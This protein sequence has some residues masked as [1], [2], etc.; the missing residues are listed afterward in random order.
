M[1]RQE[2]KNHSIYALVKGLSLLMRA[3]PLPWARM[4]GAAL[5]RLF[6]SLVPYERRKALDTFATAFPEKDSAEAGRVC[7]AAFA[8]L[9]RGG[10]EFLR[11]PSIRE[12]ELRSWVESVDGLEHLRAP[13]RAGRGVVAVTAHLGNWEVLAA[14]TA[15]EG[16]VAVVAQRVYDARFDEALNE[17]R[18]GKGITVFKRDTSVKP[19]LRW[20]KGGGILG[21]LADQDT[22]VDSL[23]VDFFGRAAK[24]PSGPAWL[25]Q[26]TGAAL[27]TGFIFRQPGGRYRMAFQKEIPVP[28]R[29]EPGASL[30]G[31]VQ[32]Y[33][34]RTEE[35]VRA[36]PDQWV[37]MH[38]RWRSR[39]EEAPADSRP[40]DRGGAG[41]QG[42]GA[43]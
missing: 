30:K 36:H 10:A 34:R 8:S 1:T 18:R 14:R 4:L 40:G 35:A 39:P 12:A 24:T 19:I 25:A 15:L 28:S 37:W 13:L 33:T 9:G 22:R 7:R 31:V 26:A 42:E 3:L 32:E 20:L 16:R 11:F 38:P 2:L 27:V 23:F 29:D 41:A 5:G 17:Y 6:F 21:V 43:I